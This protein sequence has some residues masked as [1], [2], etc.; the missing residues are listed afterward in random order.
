MSTWPFQCGER[1]PRRAPLQDGD[2]WLGGVLLREH[3]GRS[4]RHKSGQVGLGRA[5]QG[6]VPNGQVFGLN[7]D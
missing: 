5:M 6:L 3:A 2:E 7:L 1:R 4:R